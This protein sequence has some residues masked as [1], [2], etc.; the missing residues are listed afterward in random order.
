METYN[1]FRTR[2][3]ESG[4]G[5]YDPLKSR[6]I[7]GLASGLNAANLTNVKLS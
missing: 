5:G 6:V 2:Y 4:S 3:E 1:I 7:A